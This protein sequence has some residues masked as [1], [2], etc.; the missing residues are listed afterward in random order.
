MFG[1]GPGGAP[2]GAVYPGGVVGR[3]KPSSRAGL[4]AARGRRPRRRAGRGCPGRFA[5]MVRAATT[6]SRH[7]CVW[8]GARPNVGQAR[9]YRYRRRRAIL[10][11]FCL[12]L[13]RHPRRPRLWRIGAYS[14]ASPTCP[15]SA[16]S[17][18]PRAL[19]RLV[20]RPDGLHACLSARGGARVS[21]LPGRGARTRP[22]LDE[23]LG[24]VFSRA[25]R[26]QP[27]RCWCPLL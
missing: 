27:V 13:A 5:A 14:R 23:Q 9:A 18:P 3:S 12:G 10:A 4:A 11:S 24:V 16:R 15:M 7:G 6:P 20:T 17:Q 2:Y 19:H 26:G 22:C 25:T 8:S 21:G 1:T